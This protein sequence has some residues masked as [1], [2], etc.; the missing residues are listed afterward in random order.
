MGAAIPVE[1]ETDMELIETLW[2]VNNE[3]FQRVITRASAN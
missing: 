1:F 3:E 2:N